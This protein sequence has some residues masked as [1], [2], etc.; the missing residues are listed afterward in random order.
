VSTQFKNIVG[1]TSNLNLAHGK[2]GT[3]AADMEAIIR[4]TPGAIGYFD[5]AF[6]FDLSLATVALKNRWGNFVAANAE[7]V[8]LAMRAADWERLV[9][10]QDPTF[11]LDLTDTG[12]PGCW[13]MTSTTYVLVPLK[14]RVSN[15]MKV[16]EFFQHSLRQGD[17][18]A[19]K[20]GHVPLPTRA[21]SL[22][23]VAM[24]RWYSVL[25]KASPG[26]SRQR[27]AN[28]QTDTSTAA[29]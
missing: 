28:D 25:E 6:T 11:E 20:E 27:S 7:S 1:P 12:C 16:L 8:Q 9:I 21:K 26:K 29:L 10:D 18:I 4:G 2:G 14:G 22:I 17:E 24:S 19:I 3:T 13:P 23:G 5:Y 15:S